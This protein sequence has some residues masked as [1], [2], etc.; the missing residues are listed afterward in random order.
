MLQ[1]FSRLSRLI[2]TVAGHPFMFLTAMIFVAVWALSGPLFHY[3]NAWQLTIN[4]STTIITFLMVFVIQHNQNRDSAAIQIK[5]NEIIKA[6]EG[7]EN[8]LLNAED[9]TMEE[10]G[11]LKRA[12]T[13]VARQAEEENILAKE[14]EKSLAE[15]ELSDDQALHISS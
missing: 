6:L 5:L 13:E 14:E 9:K 2:S 4:T 1:H 10:L 12:Y 15:S 8:H 11:D 3:S 7:A